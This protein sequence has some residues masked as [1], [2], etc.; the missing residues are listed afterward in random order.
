MKTKK[1]LILLVIVFLLISFYFLVK[2]ENQ[3][4]DILSN[5]STRYRDLKDRPIFP[6]SF[7]DYGVSKLAMAD[8]R[9]VVLFFNASWCPTCS[10]FVEEIKKLKVPDNVLILSV[11]YDKYQN[12][13]EKYKVTYQH[14]FIEVD[15]DG[16]ELFRWSGGGILRLKKELGIE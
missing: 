9:K 5:T 8:S 1:I 4:K 2:K 16:K 7:E 6:G 14:T 3:K 12:L 13:R 15:Y 11:D 10:Q